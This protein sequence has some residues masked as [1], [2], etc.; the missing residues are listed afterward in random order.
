M[1]PRTDVHVV[2]PFLPFARPSLA[3]TKRLVVA[4]T[5]TRTSS[6]VVAIITTT[7]QPFRWTGRG[8]L[9]RT[10]HASSPRVRSESGKGERKGRLG[11]ERTRTDEDFSKD[12][13]G[14]LDAGATRYRCVRG[15]VSMQEGG[16]GTSDASHTRQRFHEARRVALVARA[17]KETKRE[18]K[19]A[20]KE[21][22]TCIKNIHVAGAARNEVPWKGQNQD[23][24]TCG[25]A[26]V[27]T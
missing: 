8:P 19:G 13:G 5:W 27:R 12:F 1:K 11:S 6:R 3:S 16:T 26:P 21:H 7:S 14:G 17:T 23:D 24:E 22:Q 9:V 15:E 10:R 20:R 18:A 2:L 4:C 25:P